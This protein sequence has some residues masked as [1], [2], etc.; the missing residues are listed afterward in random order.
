MATISPMGVT[1]FWC[2]LGE[3]MGASRDEVD[4]GCSAYEKRIIDPI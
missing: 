1:R 4:G 3:L 2:G